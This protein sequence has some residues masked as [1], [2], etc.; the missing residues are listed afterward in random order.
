MGAD[1]GAVPRQS[2][3]WATSLAVLTVKSAEVSTSRY[4][5]RLRNILGHLLSEQMVLPHL[6]ILGERRQVHLDEA[7][8]VNSP[9]ASAFEQ[10][11]CSQ[12]CDGP[13]LQ[14]PHRT[15]QNHKFPQPPY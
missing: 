15:A 14:V 11:D 12:N 9:S 7:A 4:A 13:C 1:F 8:T 2:S 10:S 5:G 3:I 6:S